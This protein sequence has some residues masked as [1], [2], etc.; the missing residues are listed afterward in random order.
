MNRVSKLSSRSSQTNLITVAT[1]RN[2]A[3]TA[4]RNDHLVRR[5]FLFAPDVARHGFVCVPVPLFTSVA[6]I[7][8]VRRQSKKHQIEYWPKH[9]A[10]CRERQKVYKMME[11]KDAEAKPYQKARGLPPL[12]ERRRIVED[13]VEV[14]RHSIE[15]ALVSAIQ[16]RSPRVDL[17]HEHV[18]FI[19]SYRPESAG[20]PSTAFALHNVIIQRDPD[21]GSTPLSANFESF[22]ATMVEPDKEMK[23]DDP[24]YIGAFLSVC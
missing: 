17:Y 13:W 22:R 15:Q 5:R 1:F 12:M 9:K 24:G 21:R 2:T 14:H 7:M 23:R 18:V 6:S 8:I 10:F 11:E 16:T 4:K 19:C 3:N 20:N